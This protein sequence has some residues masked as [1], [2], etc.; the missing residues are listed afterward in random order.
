MKADDIVASVHQEYGGRTNVETRVGALSIVNDR[1]KVVVEVA[2]VSAWLGALGR[3]ICVAPDFPGFRKILCLYK[4]V[5]TDPVGDDK[6][7]VVKRAC[8]RV[9]VD[10]RLHESVLSTRPK[11]TRR[12]WHFG[13]YATE[14]DA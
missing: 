10:L 14:V 8:E 4:S 11:R 2:D 5:W 1:E 6:L 13:W 9:R 3:L 7:K 12:W